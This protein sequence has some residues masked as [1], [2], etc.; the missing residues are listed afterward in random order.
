M[1]TFFGSGLAAGLLAVLAFTAGLTVSVMGDSSYMDC[2][3][4]IFYNNSSNLYK[5]I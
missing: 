4:L 2:G 1:T 3:R 5:S